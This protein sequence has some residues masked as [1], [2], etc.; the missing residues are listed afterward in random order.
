MQHDRFASA[1]TGRI[2]VTVG[3]AVPPTASHLQASS[4]HMITECNTIVVP[5][6]AQTANNVFIKRT[7]GRYWCRA[8]GHRR[9]LIAM[10]TGFP[11]SQH[12]DTSKEN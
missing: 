7:C 1:M 6:V 5:D 11:K 3:I 10:L 2:L 4:G 9:Q 12:F 8:N